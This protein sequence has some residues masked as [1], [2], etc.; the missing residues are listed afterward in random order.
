M[1]SIQQVKL[2]INIKLAPIRNKLEELRKE[3][4]ELT[5]QCRIYLTTMMT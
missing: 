1:A 5:N 4:S 3:Y 2:L